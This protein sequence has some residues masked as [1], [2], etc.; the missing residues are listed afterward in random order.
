M[1]SVLQCVLESDVFVALRVE[2]LGGG[3]TGVL[4]GLLG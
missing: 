2:V 1:T 4:Y 3:L